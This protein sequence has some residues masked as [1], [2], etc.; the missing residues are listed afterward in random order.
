LF[1]SN[2]TPEALINVISQTDGKIAVV[3]DEGIGFL[4]N[5]TGKYNQGKPTDSDINNCWDGGDI[6]ID[7]I[8]RERIEV[9]EPCVS[10][11]ICLQ[12]EKFKDF[13]H[14]KELLN[15]GHLFRYLTITTKQ[16]QGKR[17]FSNYSIPKDVLQ[18]YEKFVFDGLDYNI[19]EPHI[20]EFDDEAYSIYGNIWDD[21]EKR[22]GEKDLEEEGYLN[23]MK[24]NVARIAG[25]IHCLGNKEPEKHKINS[26]TL[27]LANELC[28]FFIANYNQAYSLMELD[29]TQNKAIK[30]LE[31]LQKQINETGCNIFTEQEIWQSQKNKKGFTKIEDLKIVIQVLCDRQYLFKTIDTAS[32]YRVNEHVVRN[33]IIKK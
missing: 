8:T 29:E 10:I 16:N 1:A 7:R 32:K 25:I 33:G 23:K 9:K 11:G 22:T 6:Y 24:D 2:T 19:N 30:I 27:N 15:S 3:S 20:L 18:A 5:I 4:E 13:K 31:W 26:D 12:N 28:N 14:K 21:F 17:K